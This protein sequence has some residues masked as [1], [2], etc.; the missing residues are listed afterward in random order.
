MR[1]LF[2]RLLNCSADLIS[3]VLDMVMVVLR[4]SG[5]GRKEAG[6]MLG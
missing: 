2:S 6:V 4:E 1:E 5:W 3:T